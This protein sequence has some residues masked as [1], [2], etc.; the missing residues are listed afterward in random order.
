MQTVRDWLPRGPRTK[1]SLPDPSIVSRLPLME[2]MEVAVSR[3]IRENFFVIR[4][5]IITGLIVF[6]VV[7]FGAILV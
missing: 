4:I 6:L 7:T 1:L 2:R 5:L 3:F